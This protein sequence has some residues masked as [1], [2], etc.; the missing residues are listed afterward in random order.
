MVVSAHQLTIAENAR[1]AW[2]YGVRPWLESQQAE[3]W[4]HNAKCVLIVPSHAAG[5]CLKKLIVEERMSLLGVD[6]WT[7][8]NLRTALQQHYLPETQVA[9]REDLRLLARLAA[10][11]FPDEPVAQAVARDSSDYIRARDALQA[12]NYSEN[13]L[14]ST[15]FQRL[16]AR[17]DELLEEAG[18]LSIQQLDRELFTILSR[19]PQPLLRSICLHPS[20]GAA[21]E[22][23]FLLQAAIAAAE[24][25]LVVLPPAT[26]AMAAQL[27]QEWWENRLGEAEYIAD[28]GSADYPC[29]ALSQAMLY[30][31]H[32]VDTLPVGLSLSETPAQEAAQ[33]VA[34]ALT[35]LAAED[36]AEASVSIVVGEAPV[37]AREISVLLEKLD[38]PYADGWGHF[39]APEAVQQRL[40]S[41][42]DW[43]QSRRLADFAAFLQLLTRHGELEPKHS[44]LIERS[45]QLAWENTGAEDLLVI[46]AWLEQDT[47]KHLHALRFLERWPLLPEAESLENLLAKVAPALRALGWKDSLD[48][49]L[50]RQAQALG[51]ALKQPLHVSLF[52]DWLGSLLRAPG[53]ARSARGRQGFARISLLRWAD[54]LASHHKHLI[55]AGLNGDAWPSTETEKPPLPD[56]TIRRLNQ[57]YLDE[58]ARNSRHSPLKTYYLQDSEDKATAMREAFYRLVESV[59]GS[60]LLTASTADIHNGNAELPFSDLLQ[61]AHFALQGVPLDRDAA[62]ALMDNHSPSL[63][64]LEGATSAPVPIS[65]TAYARKLRT[66]PS[67][68][69]GEYQF[70]FSKPPDKPLLLSCKTLQTA[71][72]RPV[73]V[74]CEKVLGISQPID[75]NDKQPWQKSRGIWVHDWLKLEGTGIVPKPEKECWRQRISNQARHT[76]QRVSTSYK[77]A[78]RELPDWWPPY[79]LAA[80]ADALDLAMQ[81]A[82]QADWPYVS[83]ELPLPDDLLQDTDEGPLLLRGRIDL[84]LASQYIQLESLKQEPPHALTR[85]CIIDYKTGGDHAISEKGLRK[86]DGLQLALYALAWRQLGIDDVCIG[87]LKPGMHELKPPLPV[88][89]LDALT[90]IFAGLARI[91]QKGIF[92][93]LQPLTSEHALTDSYPIATLP[94]DTEILKAKWHLERPWHQL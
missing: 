19:S 81:V 5:Q 94:V 86:G 78:H 16:G 31:G 82:E 25:A 62:A 66:D 91:Q 30:G 69:F 76:L 43:Q 79:W 58:K 93:Q 64:D 77:Q 84:L 65:D 15:A 54:A 46:E 63:D 34:H 26:G 87:I 75:F 39:A 38:L 48:E 24:E 40:H 12:A 13:V 23:A 42:I 37:L 35:S 44:R 20:L 60:L 57:H 51:K 21:W 45:L 29:D 56:A 9:L 4:K 8:G 89:K 11:D 53:R 32:C 36:L 55:L 85:L 47:P 83:S 72:S 17:L 71:L 33:V 59:T 49:R 50:G 73:Q 74:W 1:T 80:R 28:E 14:E 52:L 6:F 90:D 10:K 92:G 3:L 68:A 88:D 70:A 22:N 7:P 18:L 67:Q 61:S 2:Q 41:W 27:W